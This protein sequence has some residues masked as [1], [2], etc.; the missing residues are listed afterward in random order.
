[1]VRRQSIKEVR[2]S[3]WANMPHGT[4]DCVDVDVDITYRMY[5]ITV[6]NSP[7]FKA[8]ILFD[9]G[10]H[11]SFVN[12]GEAAWFEEQECKKESE[13]PADDKRGTRTAYHFGVASWDSVQ[14]SYIRMCGLRFNFL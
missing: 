2:L 10:A 7:S 11:A 5:C 13:L 4:L 14:Q 12:R 9:M 8:A 3:Y 6:D 1:M